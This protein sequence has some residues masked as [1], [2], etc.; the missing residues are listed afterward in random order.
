MTIDD[1][2]RYG[3]LQ[4]DINKKVAKVLAL[5]SGKTDK[6]EFLTGE[7]ILPS[8]Q[9]RIIEQAKLTY[10]SLEKTFE[11]QT[12]A[13]ESQGRKQTPKQLKSTENN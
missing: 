13:I 8:D 4:Y 2:I 10:S 3:K 11:K 9:S 1:K 12:K 7:E 5:S 6:Y